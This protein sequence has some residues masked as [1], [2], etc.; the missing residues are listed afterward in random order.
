MK[1]PSRADWG[2][3]NKDDLDAKSAFDSF[4]GK[5]FSEAEAM[6]QRNALYYQE[7]LQSMPAVPFNFYAPALVK[8]ITSEHAKGDSDGASSFLHMVSWILKSN[9]GILD[10]KTEDLLLRAARQIAKNQDYYEADV[11]IYGNFSEIYFE[12][13]KLATDRPGT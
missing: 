4:L 9:R 1:I 6:F 7:E 5:S 12:I 3:I 11:D 2:D 10:S 13:Q 8:Y